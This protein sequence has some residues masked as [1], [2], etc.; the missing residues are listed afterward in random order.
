MQH[1]EIRE[2]AGWPSGA[3]VRID[4]YDYR[5]TITAPFEAEQ[6]G[7]LDWYFEEH[8]RFPSAD[9]VR[10]RLAGESVTAYGEA[11]FRQLFAGD[12]LREPTAG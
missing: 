6:E 11:L 10:A 1:V 4:G 2:D 12:E 3:L 7:E 8:L 5:A 9:T